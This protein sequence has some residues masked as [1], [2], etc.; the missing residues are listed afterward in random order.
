MLNKAYFSLNNFKQTVQIK[1]HSTCNL[2]NIHIECIFVAHCVW[3]NFDCMGQVIRLKLMWWYKQSIGI[4]MQFLGNAKGSEFVI[5][6]IIDWSIADLTAWHTCRL[7]GLLHGR[8]YI[9]AYIFIYIYIYVFTGVINA[10]VTNMYRYVV[11]KN[12]I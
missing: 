10:E 7:S 2:I 11:K 3:T 9:Q 8:I 12:F 5:W 1:F 6:L 4:M